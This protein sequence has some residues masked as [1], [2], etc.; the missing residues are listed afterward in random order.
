M[1]RPREHGEDTAAALVAA[2]ERAV[3]DGGLATLSVRDVARAAGTTTRAVYS[4]FGSKE[5]LV[6]A[7]GARAYELL[8]DGLAAQ[9]LTSDPR[10]DIVE[11]ALMFRRF[12]LAHPSLFAIGIQ[13]TVA[14][15]SLWPRFRPA[16]DSAFADLQTRFARLEEAGLLVGRDSRE[17]ALQFHALCEGLAALELRG[18]REAE[19]E[20]TWRTAFE[21]LL[22]GFA[23]RPPRRRP[24]PKRARA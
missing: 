14:D 5:G 12:A 6:V 11:L 8:H 9:P 19:P 15:P 1:G 24:A 18:L 23:E 20:R 10:R 2:A 13:R 21:A 17:A 3:E 22:R 4:I 7:L 16:A